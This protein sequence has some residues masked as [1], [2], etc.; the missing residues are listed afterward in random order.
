MVPSSADIVLQNRRCYVYLFPRVTHERAVATFHLE[1][2]LR[3]L[4]AGVEHIRIGIFPEELVRFAFCKS[5]C[6][7]LTNWVL[8]I[9]APFF[10]RR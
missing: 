8:N 10:H 1:G 7:I 5:P 9:E 3:K 2:S 4:E 6:H